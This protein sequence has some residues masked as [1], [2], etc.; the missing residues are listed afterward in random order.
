ME[1]EKSPV[2]TAAHPSP[3]SSGTKIQLRFGNATLDRIITLAMPR[4]LPELQHMAAQ[5]FG[6]SGCLR[7]FHHGTSLLYHPS[8]M[9]EV[10]DGDIIVVRRSDCFRPGTSDTPLSTHQADFLKRPYQKPVNGAGSDYDSCLT[11]DTKGV[12]LEGMSRYATDFVRHPFAARDTW[13]PPSA[14]LLASKAKLGTTTYAGDFPWREKPARSKAVDDRAVRESSLSMASQAESFK[15]TSSYTI[16]YPRRAVT[17]RVEYA[18]A[19]PSVVLPPSEFSA[20]TTYGSDFKKLGCGRQRSAKPKAAYERTNEA[21]KGTS[22]YQ[23]EYH[24]LS[25]GSTDKSEFI[26]LASEA[27]ANQEPWN[28]EAQDLCAAAEAAARG[29]HAVDIEGAEVMRFETPV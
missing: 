10:Q 28:Q 23:R 15:G 29:G 26:K 5:H 24:K 17:P 1:V 20:S 11:D 6:H 13:K 2:D 4:S 7:L 3:A 22:E 19:P 12:P 16:D 25:M 8:Q 9:K 21:F 18:K 14:L 27:F